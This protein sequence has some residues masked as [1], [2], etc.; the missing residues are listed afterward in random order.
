M[1]YADPEKQRE[2]D[3]KRKARA[4]AENKAEES[5]EVRERKPDIRARAWTFIVYP[6][7]AP[8]TGGMCWTGFTFNGRAVRFT[9]AT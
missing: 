3:R 7:S 1:P 9:I 8:R 2:A 4:R 5:E 6:E